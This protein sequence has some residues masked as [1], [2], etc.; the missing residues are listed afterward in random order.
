MQMEAV[1]LA[2]GSPGSPIRRLMRRSYETRP[3]GT[4]QPAE[5]S[6]GD[7]V[8]VMRVA[9]PVQQPGSEDAI[10]ESGRLAAFSRLGA[11]ER[12]LHG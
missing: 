9:E 8:S 6:E 4:P 7:K 5:G 1:L 10:R 2:P 3:A 11:V 12:R